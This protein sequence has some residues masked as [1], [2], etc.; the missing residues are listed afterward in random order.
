MSKRA[1]QEKGEG[2]VFCPPLARAFRTAATTAVAL[3][4]SG[5]AAC[6]RKDIRTIRILVPDMRAER[7]AEVVVATVRNVPGVLPQS[8]SADVPTR[9]VVVSYDGLQL[10]RKNIE[11]AVADAGFRVIEVVSTPSGFWTNEI[12]VRSEA[13]RNL[14]KECQ[15][16]PP[17]ESAI[18]ASSP[19][20]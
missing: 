18:S 15:P 14:P 9:T 7:C 20:A 2:S 19:P 12:P 6:R 3:V 11:F 5:S 13:A 10:S 4:L 17:K 1:K 8:V 16:P